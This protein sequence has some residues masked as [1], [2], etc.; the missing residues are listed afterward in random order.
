MALISWKVQ[1]DAFIW[2]LFL[3]GIATLL[4]ALIGYHHYLR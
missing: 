1:S 3:G 4:G 2:G